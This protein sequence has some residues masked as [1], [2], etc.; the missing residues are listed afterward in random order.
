MSLII[1]YIGAQGCV[2][3][4]DKRRIAFF[5][6]KSNREILEDELYSGKIENES[7]LKKRA[8]EL[9]ITLKL[10]D[11][12]VK[13]RSLGKVGVGEVS[14]KS[15]FE[16]KRRRIYATTNGFQIIELTGSNITKMDKGE[17]S[18]IVFGNKFTKESAS[19]ILKKH[20]KSK[21]TLK[22]I[23]TIFQKVMEEVAQKT[24]SVGSSCD[25]FIKT[26][27]LDKKESQEI[28]RETVV[29]DVKL[30]QKWR[31]KLKKD[32]LEK[33]E[34]INLA[35]RILT[36]GEVG[37]VVTVDEDRLEIVL[38]KDVQAFDINWRQ[39]A[40]PGDKVMMFFTGEGDILEGDLVVIEN[41]SLCLKRNQ[42]P[43]R[44]DIILCKSD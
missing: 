3:A 4:G 37:R 17:S 11:D 14:S 16:T 19:N 33:A 8:S 25:L 24:P 31:Q 42:S 12:A 39:L 30:L 36:Q 38:G 21:T 29:R 32:L 10:T 20:W 2:M 44:C 7:Q 35:S 13:L 43:L 27:A 34:A 18:I 22:E 26:P 1:T 40:K 5:G 15:S 23:E 28:L 9:E 41:E 6:D